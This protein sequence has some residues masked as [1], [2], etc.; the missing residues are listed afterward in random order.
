ML[1]E[2]G[3][4]MID[5]KGRPPYKVFKHL[6]RKGLVKLERVTIHGSVRKTFVVLNKPY[7]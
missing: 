4:L 2:K 7:K 3:R 1:N 6:H 5:S